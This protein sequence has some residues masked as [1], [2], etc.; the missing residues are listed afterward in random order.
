[1]EF[2]S[3]EIPPNVEIPFSF[4]EEEEE[5][6]EGDENSSFSSIANTIVMDEWVGLGQT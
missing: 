5:G 4:E 1:M 3:N 6:D 2:T